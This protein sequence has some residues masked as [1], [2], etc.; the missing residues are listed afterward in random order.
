MSAWS[1][2]LLLIVA[3]LILSERESRAQAWIDSAGALTVGLDYSYT[4]STEVVQTPDLSFEDDQPIVAHTIAL[5]AEY[6]PIENLAITAQLP[7]L[8]VK[9]DR[10]PV[11]SFPAHGRYDDGDLHTTFTDLRLTARY[12]LLREP[13]VLFTPHLG[14]S[15]P[16]ADYETVGFATAGRGLKQLHVGAS[17]ARTLNPWVPE[18]YVHGGFEFTFGERYDKTPIT[19]VFG[20]NRSDTSLQFG[21]FLLEGKLNLNLGGNLRLAHGNGVNFTDLNELPEDVFTYHDP[22]LR[23]Q[24]LLI[25]GG[26]GYSITDTIQ[27]SLQAR[28][29]TWGYNTRNAHMFGLG[30]SWGV[31]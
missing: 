27:V 26:A 2:S 7:L 13:Y 11:M 5:S 15:I 18:L 6:V 4:P 10:T 20:Q 24:F 30:L 25:G 3:L 23:E 9:Y 8:M 21:Y 31:L 29:F 16:V 12:N 22:L 14:F 1:K 28:F 17:V 19:E